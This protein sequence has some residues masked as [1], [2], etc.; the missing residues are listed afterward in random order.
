MVSRRA[1]PLLA[2]VSAMV[3]VLATVP[4]WDWGQCTRKC[5]LEM[6]GARGMD[7]ARV[8]GA[9]SPNPLAWGTSAECALSL[10]H[11]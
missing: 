4:A 2:V 8:R 6:L 1:A 9:R 11:I 3:A 5:R 7:D 10:I